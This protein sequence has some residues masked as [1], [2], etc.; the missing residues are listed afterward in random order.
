MRAVLLF[1]LV[2]LLVSGALAWQYGARIPDRFNPWAPLDVEEAPNLLTRFKLQRLESDPAMCRAVLRR[3]GAASTPVP[4]RSGQDGCGWHDAV[5]L[6]TI[7]HARLQPPA[8]V[9]C[10]LAVSL[11]MLDRHAL[12]PLAEAGFHEH[13]TRIDNVGSYACRNNQGLPG[14]PLS[15]HATA[16]AIDVTGVVLADGRTITVLED[17]DRGTAGV[18]L[19]AVEQRACGFFGTVLGPEYNAAHR[20]HFHLQETGAGWC[21]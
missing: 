21:R 15:R 3:S 6:G 2:L 12:Q 11:A 20:G 17:W 13:V 18:F 14:A 9:S 7:G 8:V 19:H 4:D 5:R 1:I 16:Q 10:P